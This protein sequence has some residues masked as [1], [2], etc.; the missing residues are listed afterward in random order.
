MGKVEEKGTSKVRLINGR[1]AV[2]TGVSLALIAVFASLA[3]AAETTRTEYKAAVEPI[4]Q[5][6]ASANKKI[7]A[8]AR[9][10][11]TQGRLKVAASK[12]TKAAAA[13]TKTQRELDAVPKPPADATRLE[14]WLAYVKTEAELLQSASKALKADEVNKA[15]SFVARL[16]HNAN[17][18]NSQIVVFGFRYCR[19]KPSDYT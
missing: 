10:D 5:A 13:V 15:R 17:L 3:F 8:G 16:T 9:T 12:F 2:T 6:N 14:K 19:F 1:I 11:V 18:A 4:C 7:L